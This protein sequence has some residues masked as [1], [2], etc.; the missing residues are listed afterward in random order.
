MLLLPSLMEGGANVLIE[1]VTCGVPVLASRIPGSI[2]MLGADYE[3][4]FDVGD[5]VALA[6]LIAR[7]RAEPAL[8]DRLRAQAAARA[9]LFAPARERAAVRA[10]AHNLLAG[11]FRRTP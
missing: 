5:E 4:W 2:G 10:L 7:C 8:L 9:P 1:A 3:G 6:A 11:T